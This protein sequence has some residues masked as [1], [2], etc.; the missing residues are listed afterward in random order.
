[1]A[2]LRAKLTISSVEHLSRDIGAE[3]RA[4][5]QQLICGTRRTT[6]WKIVEGIA[7]GHVQCRPHCRCERLR[8]HS[9]EWI[10]ADNDALWI[11][12][13][14]LCGFLCKC[15]GRVADGI[16]LGGRHLKKPEVSIVPETRLPVIDFCGCHH[17]VIVLNQPNCPRRRRGSSPI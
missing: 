11:F 6:S 9:E 13:R 1:M 2:R 8:L 5:L 7:N 17:R 15:R 14:E 10:R 12:S 4:V 16:V 3:D